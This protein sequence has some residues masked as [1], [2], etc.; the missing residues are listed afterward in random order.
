MNTHTL[1]YMKAFSSIV[2]I[3][4]YILP[5]CLM[6]VQYF[7]IIIHLSIYSFFEICLD[8]IG[9]LFHKES[10]LVSCSLCNI[11]VEWLLAQHSST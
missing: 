6:C 7:V 2:Y 4:M 10:L 11:V 9:T 8:L 5:V 1:L 3:H